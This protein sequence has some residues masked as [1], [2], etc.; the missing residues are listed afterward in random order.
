M[1][2]AIDPRWATGL[3]LA[4]TRMAAFAAASPVYARILPGFGRVA[5]ALVL[6]F[7]FT[8]PVPVQDLAGLVTAG[9]VNAVVGLALGFLTGLL[10]Q[11]FQVAGGIV[12]FSSGLSVSGVIDPMTGRQDTVFGRIFGIASGAVFLALGGDRLLIAGLGRSLAVIP[13]DGA[14]SPHSGLADLAVSLFGKMMMAGVEL[15]LP[16]VA[17]LFIVE[18]ALGLANRL[19]P[20]LNAFIVGMPVKVLVSLIVVSLVILAFPSLMNGVISETWGV[21]SRTLTGLT[22]G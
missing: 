10:F 12:D 11:V 8:A 19:V 17:A 20:Q 16:A 15:A 4:S 2:F 1:E 6:G 22:S 7:F 14:P 9:F 3:A 5:M 21:L 13:L 18:L